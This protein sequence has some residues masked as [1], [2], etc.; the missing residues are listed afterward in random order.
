MNRQLFAFTLAAMFRSTSTGGGCQSQAGPTLQQHREA[1]RPDT[2]PGSSL[3]KG[4]QTS[5]RPQSPTL[6]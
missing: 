2:V 4:S 3:S 1:E 5:K 6:V